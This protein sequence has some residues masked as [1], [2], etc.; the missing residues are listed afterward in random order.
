[1]T[2]E[3]TDHLNEFLEKI[4]EFQKAAAVIA[5]AMLKYQENE[6]VMIDPEDIHFEYGSI[7]AQ[8]Y[9]RYNEEKSICIPP[10]YFFDDSWIETAKRKLQEEKDRKLQEA[11]K[12]QERLK[13]RA[14]ER[15]RELYLE[16]KKKFEGT[17]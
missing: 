2:F 13:Q 12:H 17:E 16:L 8:Y 5:T 10:K 4:E 6:D 11:L 3:T 7:V 1:M 15:E 9:S 14:K